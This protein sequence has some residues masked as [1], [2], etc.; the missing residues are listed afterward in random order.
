MSA[1]I[2]D[3]L[4]ANKYEQE[5]YLI[6]ILANKLG[7]PDHEVASKILY[8]LKKLCKSWKRKREPQ[9]F[10]DDLFDVSSAETAEKEARYPDGI[11]TFGDT[12]KYNR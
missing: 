5:K 8:Q 10:G 4:I 11:R 2:A 1:T 12:P 7:D 9:Q 6:E 3:L